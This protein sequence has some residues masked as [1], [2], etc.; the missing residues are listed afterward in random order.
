VAHIDGKSDPGAWADH[1]ASTGRFRAAAEE[2]VAL[3]RVVEEQD[4]EIAALLAENKRLREALG[5]I[6]LAYDM[7]N[8]VERIAT[9]ALRGEGE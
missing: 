3:Q 2:A 9:E 1:I 7:K 8:T 6:L 4:A 5:A